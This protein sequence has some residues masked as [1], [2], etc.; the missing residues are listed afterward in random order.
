MRFREISA[1]S[2]DEQTLPRSRCAD[3]LPNVVDMFSVF[4][5]Q[6]VALRSSSAAANQT[7]ELVWQTAEPELFWTQDALWNMDQPVKRAGF[8]VA[9]V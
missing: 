9:R 5:L 4:A 7:A 6:A 8:R 1:D 2:Q 3:H